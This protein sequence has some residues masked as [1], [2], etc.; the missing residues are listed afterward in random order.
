METD[1][2]ELLKENCPLLQSELLKTVA[3]TEE[4]LSGGGKSR[5]VWAQFS[6]GGDTTDRRRHN[7][8]DVGE[9]GQSLWVQSSDG[10]D[11]RGMSP[12]QEG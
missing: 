6:D 8:E 2:F 4:E 12:G 5:S 7:W 1:G 10:G 3:G 9:R 11:A